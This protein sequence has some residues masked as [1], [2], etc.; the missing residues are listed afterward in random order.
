MFS[1]ESVREQIDLEFGGLI[2]DYYD[3]KLLFQDLTVEAG[4]IEDIESLEKIL[5]ERRLHVEWDC[6]LL[7][8]IQNNNKK[9]VDF[10]LKNM[11]NRRIDMVVN[12]HEWFVEG[13]GN[14][15]P[16]MYVRIIPMLTYKNKNK[17]DI[18]MKDLMKESIRSKNYLA[19]EL[20]VKKYLNI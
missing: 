2:P 6:A 20:L 18:I 3:E 7:D 19:L 11:E 9:S 13:L 8:F 5:S 4:L 10:V 14:C 15:D 12:E 1:L 17:T 16:E